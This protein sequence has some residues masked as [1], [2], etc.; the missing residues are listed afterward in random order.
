MRGPETARFQTAVWTVCPRHAISFG[1]PTLTDSS[2]AIIVPDF[3]SFAPGLAPAIT[4]KIFSRNRCGHLAAVRLNQALAFPERSRACLSTQSS[5][6][7][8]CA[9]RLFVDRGHLERRL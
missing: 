5:A 3:S 7:P 4:A 8:K 2:C 1:R 6:L 9:R